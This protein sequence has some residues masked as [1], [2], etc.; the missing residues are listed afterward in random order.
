VELA[1]SQEGLNSMKKLVCDTCGLAGRYPVS[2]EH[3]V[4]IFR[5]DVYKFWK[6]SRNRRRRGNKGSNWANGNMGSETVL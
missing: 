6:C 1:A 3:G 5:E 2:Y 4:S